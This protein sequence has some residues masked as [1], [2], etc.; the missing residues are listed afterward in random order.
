MTNLL[1]LLTFQR[2]VPYQNSQT[3]KQTDRHT[4][5]VQCK[6]I[7]F[8]VKPYKNHSP[9]K[10]ETREVNVALSSTVYICSDKRPTLFTTS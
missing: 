4:Y 8:V 7:D 3:A 10:Y 6:G 2:C 9:W 1:H 5:T